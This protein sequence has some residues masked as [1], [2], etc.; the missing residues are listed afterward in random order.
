MIGVLALVGLSVLSAI[1]V[2]GRFLPP[3]LDGPA[4]ALAT[5]R[6]EGLASGELATAIAGSIGL[7]ALAGLGSWLSF[8]HQEL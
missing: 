3:G 6:I 7:I 4:L 1:P 2:V 8:R 5:G